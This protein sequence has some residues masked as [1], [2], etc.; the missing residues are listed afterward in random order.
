[1]SIVT[2][3]APSPTGYLHLGHA[4]AAWAAWKWARRVGGILRLRLEDIDAGRCRPEYAAAIPEDLVWLGLD[5]DG[6]IRTQSAHLPEYRAA[7][8][9]LAGRGLLYPCF[10]SRAEIARAQAAPH[11][12]EAVYPG[13]CKRLDGGERDERIAAGAP[14]AMRLDVSRALKGGPKLRFFEEGVGWVAARPA[15]LGDVVLAR[16]DVPTSYHLCVVH[17]DAVQ[18][19]THVIRG[20][21]LRMATHIHVLLQFLLGVATPV[22]RFHRLITD[23]AGKRLAKRDQ[24]ASLRG[25]RAAGVSAAELRARLEAMA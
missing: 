2:R 21:D 4:Y 18:G 10:C 13:T 24:A 19:V 16:R 14:Y 8:D 7:L 15:A 17:D 6:D 3:F 25:M 11:G 5:W 20:E 23:E 1:M 12:A 22:Y 9:R